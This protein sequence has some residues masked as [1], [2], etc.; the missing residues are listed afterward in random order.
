[1]PT[2]AA[3]LLQ[4]A[5]PLPLPRL[6]DYLPPPGHGI[7][8][9][10]IGPRARAL[11]ATASWSAD[12][13]IGTADTGDE[14]A[15]PGRRLARPAARCCRASCA[16][17]RWLA[18]YTHAPLG[19]VFATALPGTLRH[20][21]ALPDTRMGLAADRSRAPR[22]RACGGQPAAPAGRTAGRRHWM[23]TCWAN[24]STVGA[25]C[26][27]FAGRAR[28]VASR[29]ESPSIKRAA[30]RH[31]RP[32]AE[33]EPGRH[34]GRDRRRRLPAVPADG[35]TGSGKTEVYLQAIIHCLARGRQALVLVPEIGLT[36]QTL[37]RFRGRLG[38]AGACAAFGLERQRRARLGGLRRGEARV[39]VGTRSAVFTPLPQAGLIVDEEHDGSYKQQD[40]IRYHARD[41]ALVRAKALG[42]G[43]AGQ[44][45]AV[46]GNAAQRLCRAL[47]PPAPEA[48]RRRCAATARAHPRRK[49]PLH[50]GLS[51]EC[52]PASASTCAR[53]AGAGVQEPPRLRTRLLCHDCGWTAHATLR[54]A[55]DRAWR[56]RRLQ[57]HHCGARRN[58]RRWPAPPA[59]AW[60]CNRRASAPNAWKNCWS[61]FADFPV[62]RIDRGTTA[63]R[64]A[65]QQMLGQLGDA[66]GIL[67]GTQI[68]AKGHDLPNSPGW[69]WWAWTKG[70]IPRIS[71]PAR[72]WPSS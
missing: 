58:R 29:L 16:R 52:W 64:D 53:P 20:G 40:G 65:L 2:H 55:D 37:A 7:S 24:A 23:K 1:M 46:A 62:V 60:R 30:A 54:C 43:A 56:R 68:L 61:A 32:G 10:D 33:P 4:V 14:R 17:L 57:C 67:V 66:P 28:A 36:P 48:A 63:R 59:A 50:D 34:R 18:R 5:L 12:R 42:A 26:G 11:S 22:C 71:A 39:I 21:E 69:W 6:F 19:E 31:Q 51:P 44:R 70:F 8:E 15:A 25:R 3:R 45:H 35:V 41:F 47:H 27:A 49:R 13:G 9:A 72:S 38:I